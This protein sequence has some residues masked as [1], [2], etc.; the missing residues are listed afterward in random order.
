ME[1]NI[2]EYL[3]N[4]TSYNKVLTW[5]IQHIN[6]FSLKFQVEKFLLQ[7]DGGGGGVMEEFRSRH[8]SQTNNN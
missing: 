7:E 5:S 3:E 2:S 4:L 8:R 6:L 1:A